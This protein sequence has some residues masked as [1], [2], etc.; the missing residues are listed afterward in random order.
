MEKLIPL[1]EAVGYIG[2]FGMLFAETGLLVGFFLPGDTLLFAAGILASKGFFSIWI[3]LI[4]SCVAAVAGDSFGY[5]IGR[6][7]GPKVFVRED[8]LFFKREY[9]AR[10]QHFFERHGRK[11]IFLSRFIPIVRTFAPVVAGVGEMPYRSFI[12]YNI[13]GGITW[14]CSLTLAGY[15]LGTKIANIDKYILPI[16]IGIIVLSFWPVVQQV[17]IHRRRGRDPE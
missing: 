6:K 7:L 14:C 16:I 9:V 1:I 13:A 10:A 17:L 8:S 3:L 15:F 12:F 5:Y 11:T 4:G 2:V